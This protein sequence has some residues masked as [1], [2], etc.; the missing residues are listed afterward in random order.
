VTVA[1][2]VP[3]G[4]QLTGTALVGF[5]AS[6]LKLIPGL[7]G[8][9]DILVTNQNSGDVTRLATS[10]GAFISDDTM[11]RFR[12]GNDPFSWN[13]TSDTVLSVQRTAGLVAGDF[14]GTGRS[15]VLTINPG[16]QTFALLPSLA[17]GGFLNPIVSEPL[18]Y[19]PDIVAAGTFRQGGSLDFATLDEETGTIR[20]YLGNGAGTFALNTNV[21]GQGRS[22]LAAGN[23]PVG[24]NVADVNRDGKLDL[25]V[26]NTFGDILVLIGNGDGTFQP[27]QRAA[28]GIPLA[29]ADLDGNGQDDF[30]FANRS[31][32]YVS[33]AYNSL[34]PTGL[35]ASNQNP[36]PV[37]G[38]GAVK[39]ADLNGDSIQDL[40]VAN[41]GSNNVL[42]YLGNADHTFQSA[43]SF[44]AGTNPTSITITDVI[45][46]DGQLIPDLN[47]DTIPDLVIVNQGSNDVSVLHGKGTGASWTMTYGPRLDSNGIGPTSAQVVQLPG[48][49][50]PDIIVTN[51]VSENVVLLPGVGQ[52]FFNDNG[53]VLPG[54]P[55]TTPIPP[56][57]RFPDV[58]GAG[59]IALVNTPSG[60][61]FVVLDT[62]GNGL[63]QFTNFTGNNFTIDSISTGG[64]RPVALVTGDFNRD[65]FT[66][67]IVANS[68]GAGGDAIGNLALLL[69]TEEGY[70]VAEIFT[71]PEL[72]HPSAVALSTLDGD[73]VF[74]A[75]TE[76]REHAF[77]FELDLEGDLPVAQLQSVEGASESVAPTLVP[78][79]ALA[80]EGPLKPRTDL[81]VLPGE[82]GSFSGD[83][84]TAGAIDLGAKPFTLGPLPLLALAEGG[85]GESTDYWRRFVDAWN[86]ARATWVP[87]IESAVIEVWARAVEEIGDVVGEIQTVVGQAL[88]FAGVND[89]EF[90]GV[91][92][93]NIGASI[94][95]VTFSAA[96][97][98][99]AGAVLSELGERILASLQE[100]LEPWEP[101]LP[102]SPAPATVPAL[103]GGKE[104][105]RILG[106]VF[107]SAA[108]AA[109]WQ[110][111][112]EAI[113]RSLPE[114][115]GAVPTPAAQRERSIL[116]PSVG[117][118]FRLGAEEAVPALTDLAVVVPQ[119]RKASPTGVLWNPLFARERE[120]YWLALAAVVILPLSGVREAAPLAAA[121]TRDR[122]WWRTS[123]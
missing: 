111:T 101:V 63:R 76:G 107:G 54:T 104:V 64:F 110:Q 48:H 121:E 84:D 25:M 44:F 22:T 26:G 98:V 92:L 85:K 109:P 24:L 23:A 87:V 46:S 18:G 100:T 113:S 78:A 42:I 88:S 16:A 79:S 120:A 112:V 73:S 71:D 35:L 30:I 51:S 36:Q 58:T 53:T 19:S 96:R 2:P 74:Y 29:V 40:I 34:D 115:N 8:R 47:G 86:E 1:V 37:L 68:N 41:S 102:V 32:D 95:D 105:L 70:D 49:A 116:M 45:G 15:D 57:I 114:A 65:G 38:P 3:G 61:G 90:P 108:P 94:V 106:D 80:G 89:L 93:R 39:F 62:G 72:T 43:V 28:R 21:D 81:I 13:T 27:Y 4:F 55:P 52:G 9:Q 75:T 7:G 10:G 99:L 119:D 83:G 118:W 12:A 14:R 117:A 11:L 50:N 56:P 103:E 5:G 60:P 123:R 66:D 6:D 122:H 33:V 97:T 59:Q 67:L 69:A 91:N 20:V 77:R 17:G 82:E 31:A